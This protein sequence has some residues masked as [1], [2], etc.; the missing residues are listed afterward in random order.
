MLIDPLK[1]E[2]YNVT[3]QELLS[4]FDRNNQLIAAGSVESATA[5]FSVTV[6]GSIETLD[7][8]YSLPVKV[9]GDRVVRLGDVTEISYNFV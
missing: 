4:V 6:P 1:L 8:I 9:N 2:S 7:D 3:A 5:A